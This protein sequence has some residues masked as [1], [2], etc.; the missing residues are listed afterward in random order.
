M[1][2]KEECYEAETLLEI[3]GLESI[4]KN[5]KETLSYCLSFGYLYG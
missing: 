2:K 3:E 5:K 1:A 4:I